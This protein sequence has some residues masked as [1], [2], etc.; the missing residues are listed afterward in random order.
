M[1][2]DEAQTMKRYDA[3]KSGKMIEEKENTDET[4]DQNIKE[5][6]HKKLCGPHHYSSMRGTSSK[7]FV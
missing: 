1:G 3:A 7:N 6:K 5:E 2:L 4:A